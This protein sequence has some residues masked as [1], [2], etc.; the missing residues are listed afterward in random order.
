VATGATWWYYSNKL[1]AWQYLR[2][3]RQRMADLTLG[4]FNR[5]PYCDVKGKDGVVHL[6]PPG[7][8]LHGRRLQS[9]DNAAVYLILDGK[10]YRIPDAATYSNLF[11]NRNGIEVFDLSAI[12]QGGTISTYAKLARSADDPAVYLA[13]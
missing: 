13:R 1:G 8:E 4:H 5:D 3:S 12:P 7:P 11:R 9:P 6:T 10:R 2:D